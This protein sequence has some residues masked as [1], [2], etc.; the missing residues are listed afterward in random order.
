MNYP[1]QNGWGPPWG[2]A[3]QAMP[4]FYPIPASGPNTPT[5]NF[6]SWQ[7]VQKHAKMMAKKELK[8]KAKW[9]A[10]AKKKDEEKKK[11]A[12]PKMKAVPLGPALVLFVLTSPLIGYP[13]LKMY[14]TLFQ[15]W[16]AALR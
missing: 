16:G 6:A 4:V 1:Y 14:Q 13:M 2:G 10:D 8:L 7:E 11:S 9:E 15:M 5:P 12:S 3:P